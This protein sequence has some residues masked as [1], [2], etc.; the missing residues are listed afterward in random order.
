MNI[1]T[2]SQ[3]RCQLGEGPVWDDRNESICWV[4]IEKGEV[5]QYSL[6]N[7]RL[8]SFSINEKVG[9]IAICSDGN[10]VIAAES[11]VGFLNRRNGEV[12]MFCDPESDLP[13]NRFNDGKCDPAG[14]FWAGTM[15]MEDEDKK[16]AL[17]SFDNGGVVER[18]RKIG[19][20]N[21]LAWSKDER[22]LYYIDTLS[23]EVVAYD[24]ELETGEIWNKR[25]V[26]RF[27]ETDGYPDGM[28]I[29]ADGMLWIAHWDG[30]QLSRWNPETNEKIHTIEFPV[31]RVTSCTF[32]G[33]GLGDLFVTSARVGLS[34]KE[35]D[36]QPLAG[37]LFVI[38]DCGFSGMPTTEFKWENRP[39]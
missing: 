15:S 30:W 12:T 24:F 29:D 19:I 22:T 38:R 35:L 33:N 3:H 21:G 11:G 5:H 26:I 4:D 20:S 36:E 25:S 23:F 28:T 13:H 32:G 31:S 27:T 17:Y 6:K 39:K 1:E 10:F 14:R 2:I 7:D 18:I 16:G 34:E 9:S 8:E 37:S